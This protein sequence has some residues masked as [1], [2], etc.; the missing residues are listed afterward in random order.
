MGETSIWIYV[1]GIG[2]LTTWLLIPW[3]LLKRTVHQSAAVAW[4]LTIVFMPYFGALLCLLIGTTRW[5]RHSRRKREA[6]EQM[7]RTARQEKEDVRVAEHCLGRWSSIAHLASDLSQVPVVSGNDVQLLPDTHRSMEVMEEM[8]EAAE[9]WVHVEFYIWKPD[10]VGARLRDLLI[11]KAR[12]GVRVRLLYD[13]IGSIQLNREFLRPL[14]EAGAR[15]ALF[16]PGFSFWHL[17][18]LNLRNHRKLIV[19][20]RQEA[21][22]GG[23]NVG[24]EHVRFT[25]SY[26]QWRDTQLLVRGPAALQVQQVFAEDWYY[27]T[28]EELAEDRFCA[29]PRMQGQ[30]RA[31]VVADGPDTE[32]NKFYMLALAALGSARECVTMTTPYFVPPDGL[33]VALATT[34][35][36]GVRVRLMIA[37]RGSFVWTLQA[38]RSYYEP[39]LNAG[40][41]IYE[42]ERG[43]YHAKT[44]SIDGE[45]ALT[46]TANWDFRSLILN[47]ELGVLLY[48]SELAKQL[49]QQFAHDVESSRRID[50]T[51]W[52]QRPTL[53]RLHEQF[54][55]LFAPML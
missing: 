29:S 39:L 19:T 37:R 20:D 15:T 45:L 50:A 27:A 47:F 4:I 46:G 18:T 38:A 33:A 23:M 8:I 51:T 2:Y 13:G 31:Q 28:E 32:D 49:E 17:M 35:R 24:D 22:T 26:G 11:R 40:V 16:T 55:R 54:W 5:E 53:V 41:E 36:R 7:R 43:L 12:T 25:Q 44:L 3:V 21:F 14:K 6:S 30:V 1:V 42:Y 34:A 52:H 48:D 10:G 9:Q